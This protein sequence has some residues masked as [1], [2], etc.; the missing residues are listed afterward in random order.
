[1]KENKIFKFLNILLISK[2][3]LYGLPC[4][5]VRKWWEYRKYN[6][7]KMFIHVLGKAK[8]YPIF[9]MFI[10]INPRLSK[11]LENNFKK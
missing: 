3:L 10:K 11:K 5:S 7:R 4:R 1:M 2:L 9:S 8:L 6:T